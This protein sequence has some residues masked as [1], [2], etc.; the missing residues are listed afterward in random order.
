MIKMR[1]ERHDKDRGDRHDTNIGGISDK[2][3]KGEA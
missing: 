1:G 3:E 2:D